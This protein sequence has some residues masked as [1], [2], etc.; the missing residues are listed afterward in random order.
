M[1]P[2]AT[3]VRQLSQAGIG[4]FSMCTHDRFKICGYGVVF[5]FICRHSEDHIMQ[6]KGGFGGGAKLYSTEH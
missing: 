2:L 1:W 4:I 6:N 5:K 3:R